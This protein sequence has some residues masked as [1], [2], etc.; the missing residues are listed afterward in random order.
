MATNQRYNQ[1]ILLPEWGQSG[2]DRLKKSHVLCIGAGGLGCPV[3]QYL[4]AAGVGKIT[5]VDGDFIE[6]SNLQRQVLFDTDDIGQPK[7]STARKHL[8]RLNPHV[9][10]CAIDH[11]LIADNALKIAKDCHLIID[12]ADNLATTFLLN[13]LA[14]KLRVPM[15]YAAAN[16]FQAQLSVFSPDNACYRCLYP[17]YPQHLTGNCAT[18]GVA[19]ALVGI[20]GSMQA[21]E[22][23][24]FLLNMHP[25]INTLYT[26]DA[27]TM[28]SNHFTINKDPSCPLCSKGNIIL[29]DYDTPI[30]NIDSVSE[31]PKDKSYILID[32]RSEKEWQSGH[33]PSAVHISLD[34]ITQ[35]KKIALQDKHATYI[36]YCQTGARSKRAAAIFKEQGFSCV[37]YLN[38][39]L[40]SIK[41]KN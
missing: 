41:L 10:I 37:R 4:T 27:K 26:L 17:H 34:T 12:A 13:D 21:M 7:A 31:L 9:E 15:V 1:Q 20:I 5:L 24:K 28:I 8:A 40:S 25:L 6:L 23:I 11:Y 2:Q 18:Q 3:S 29:H 39:S 22:T 32:T 30:C 19:G 36:L 16:Q 33:M 35:D 38:A 14:T